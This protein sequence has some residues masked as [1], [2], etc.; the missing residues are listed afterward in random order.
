MRGYESIF[1][2]C[3]CTGNALKETESFSVA[4]GGK[5]R[6]LAIS[7]DYVEIIGGICFF[8]ERGLLPGMSMIVGVLLNSPLILYQ[9]AI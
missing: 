9:G 7:V 6:D 5:I 1:Y 8:K 3:R 4:Y 2:D